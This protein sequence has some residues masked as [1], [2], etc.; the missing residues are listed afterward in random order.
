MNNLVIISQLF[1]FQL[2]DD[3][4]TFLFENRAESKVSTH[5]FT[6]HTKI[7]SDFHCVSH[8]S[9]V[10][11]PVMTAWWFPGYHFAMTSS[12]ITLRPDNVQCISQSWF[13]WDSPLGRFGIWFISVN[14]VCGS[15]NWG[16][17]F[18]WGIHSVVLRFQMNSVTRLGK[19]L[20]LGNSPL[21]CYVDS[22]KF[23][24]Q[25]YV[26]SCASSQ[27]IRYLLLLW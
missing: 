10:F 23:F 20:H 13:C 18:H 26:F 1:S 5:F 3:C 17:I 19:C 27:C 25:H 24:R 22:C 8:L 14:I 21:E 7:I 4:Y 12:V 2:C 6:I 9:C 15:F 11:P 16:I